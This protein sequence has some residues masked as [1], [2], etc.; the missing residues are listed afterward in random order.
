LQFMFQENSNEYE[1]NNSTTTEDD[2]YLW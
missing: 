2:D 1:N